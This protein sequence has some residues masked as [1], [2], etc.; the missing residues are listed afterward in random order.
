MTRPIQRTDTRTA[1]WS[2]PTALFALCG[3]LLAAQGWAQVAPHPAPHTETGSS[4]SAAAPELHLQLSHST[5]G[6]GDDGVKRSAEFSERLYRN[7]QYVWVERVIPQGAHSEAAHSEADKE[8]R[9]LDV[10]A[11]SRWISRTADGKTEVRLVLPHDKVVVNV[12][13]TDY[14]NIGFD[15]SW[16]ALY[17]LID[18]AMLKE[19]QAGQTSANKVTYTRKTGD[20]QVTVVWDTRL[21]IPLRVETRTPNSSRKTEVKVLPLAKNWPWEQVTGFQPKDY[22]DYLD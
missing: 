15:G 9:H 10:V 18:P 5:V 2:R 1:F 17:H 3:C 4:A 19:M 11:A 13:P 6:V 20:T 12:P 7:K 14:A 22:S 21:Q 16:N 8:H